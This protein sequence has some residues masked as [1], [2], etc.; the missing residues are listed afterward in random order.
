[1]IHV[2]LRTMSRCLLFLHLILDTFRDREGSHSFVDWEQDRHRW[3][4]TMET[5]SLRYNHQTG[6]SNCIL[7]DCAVACTSME[8]L[9]TKTSGC[10]RT[11]CT[12]VNVIVRRDL[13]GVVWQ[14]PDY[15]QCLVCVNEPAN[16]ALSRWY[17]STRRRLFKVDV[18]PTL[19][20]RRKRRPTLKRRR[21]K[22]PF[23]CRLLRAAPDDSS[24]R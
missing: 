18:G 9:K 12:S 23:R 13:T 11:L 3:N 21:A 24:T 17:R 22:V 1:M 2:R 15:Q 6:G 16:G 5:S 19:K 8:A 10:P 7:D 20:R 4:V 14:L